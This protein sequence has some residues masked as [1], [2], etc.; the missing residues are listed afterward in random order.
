MLGSPSQF[1]LAYCHNSGQRDRSPRSRLKDVRVL[2]GSCHFSPSGP[3][4]EA[5]FHAT[6]MPT[7]QI[8]SE[9]ELEPVSQIMSEIRL[10]ATAILDLSSLIARL[11]ADAHRQLPSDIRNSIAAIPAPAGANDQLFSVARVAL[12]WHCRTQAA[13]ERLVAAQARLVYFGRTGY[14]RLSDLLVIEQKQSAPLKPFPSRLPKT[15]GVRAP[16]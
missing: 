9:S 10:A 16:G 12:R 7:N 14:L 8:N 3:R 1:Q 2:G 6:L 4:Q 13:Y 15:K 5:L 11:F